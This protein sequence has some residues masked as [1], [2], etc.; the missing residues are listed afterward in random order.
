MNKAEYLNGV[1]ARLNEL[2]WDDSSSGMFLGGDTSKVERLVETTFVDA[3]RRA[4][5]LLPVHYFNRV[6][7]VH[8]PHYPDVSVGTGVVELPLDFYKLALFRMQGW[9]RAAFVAVEEND[10]IS[11]IQSNEFVRGNITRPV[12]VLAL[13]PKYGRVLKYYS[14]PCGVEHVVAEAL[15]V[16]LVTSLDSA[17]SSLDARLVEPLMWLNATVVLQVLEKVELAKVA[18]ERSF[19]IRN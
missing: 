2:G 6:S 5:S 14:L 17:V 8:A 16:G 12:C 9:K 11:S 18:E 4:T 15:Y 3:W 10:A 7:F 1:M 13:H 19:L